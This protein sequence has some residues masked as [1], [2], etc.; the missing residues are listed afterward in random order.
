MQLPARQL[1][2]P[3]NF[4]LVNTHP[5]WVNASTAS[6][7]GFS[8]HAAQILSPSLLGVTETASAPPVALRAG[9]L[10]GQLLPAGVCS[11]TEYS[12]IWAAESW[13]LVCTGG[14]KS[15]KCP[16]K[17]Q[18]LRTVRVSCINLP[19]PSLLRIDNSGPYDFLDL[20]L[21]LSSSFPH[22][23][24]C[25]SQPCTGTCLF[26]ASL[27]HFPVSVTWTPQSFV[28]RSFLAEFMVRVLTPEVLLYRVLE[29][30]AYWLHDIKT[31]GRTVAAQ[32]QTS[33][34]RRAGVA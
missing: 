32:L 16:P 8:A 17:H 22:E 24:L 29:L 10:F 15:W 1:P 23:D 18:W 28:Y 3:P 11:L 21:G 31:P 33:P 20:L 6:F 2:T 5:S 12:C 34:L 26:P 13:P 7:S 4:L 25:S 30:M 19:V 9:I 27:P 14:K